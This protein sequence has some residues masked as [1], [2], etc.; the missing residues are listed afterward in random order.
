M[1]KLSRR[2]TW[3]AFSHGMFCATP[4]KTVSNGHAYLAVRPPNNPAS[5][6]RDAFVPVA[7]LSLNGDDS[8]T[9]IGDPQSSSGL[10]RSPHEF[11]RQMESECYAEDHK[12]SSDESSSLR[13]F[14][15]INR[16]EILSARRVE[17]RSGSR[18]WLT[19]ICSP[20]P[21]D[22]R[23]SRCSLVTCQSSVKHLSPPVREIR[24]LTRSCVWLEATL[25]RPR[26]LRPLLL[27]KS[28]STANF[29]VHHSSMR[30]S[31]STLTGAEVARLD[32]D[33]T[34]T[35]VE[36]LALLPNEVHDIEC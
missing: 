27:P 12:L 7:Y 28:F 19:P 11:G 3:T 10:F 23:C 22:S 15:G 21:N 1:Q 20:P 17:E 5:T 26:W 16:T 18:W 30:V 4:Q 24:K 13:N 33:A 9:V 35:L 34:V 6:C 25:P 2:H 36:L 32:T 31:I 14:L 8:G 29:L